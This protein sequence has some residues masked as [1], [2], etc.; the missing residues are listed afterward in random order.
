GGGCD[1]SNGHSMGRHHV[2]ELVIAANLQAGH[3]L[4]H[5]SRVDVEQRH[6]TEAARSKARVPGQRMT[7]V[8]NADDDDRPVLRQPYLACDLE[9]KVL[10]V[11]AHA[12]SAVRTEI[13]QVLSQLG[14]V[15]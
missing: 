3:P 13:R 5:P 1:H 10:D 7:E 6:D 11:V 2:L 9:A 12:T 14:R 15:D 8:S 4:T